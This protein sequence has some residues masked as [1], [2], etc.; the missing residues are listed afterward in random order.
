MHELG[1]R[2]LLALI[3]LVLITGGL[4]VAT[5]FRGF[6]VWHARKSID[7]V[8]WL[9][10]VP[11]WSWMPEQASE[12]RI[13]RQASLGRFIGAVFAA[14]GLIMLITSFLANFHTA[15]RGG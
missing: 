12:Q 2:L 5:N 11:P 13:A 9:E 15:R 7:Y 8:K 14:G 6:T 1:L 4:A 3:G 10:R